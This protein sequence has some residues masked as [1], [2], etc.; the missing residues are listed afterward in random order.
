VNNKERITKMKKYIVTA[1]DYG[2]TCDG[3]ARVLEVCNTKDEAKAFVCADI[4]QWVDERAGENIVVD[5]DKMI[6]SVMDGTDN[7]CEWNIE[8]RDIVSALTEKQIEDAKQCL[9]D[10]GIDEDEADTVLQALGYILLD[11]EVIA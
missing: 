8:C 9:I 10:N 2:E 5:F 3:K 7:G 1:V 6:V 11:M 4:E